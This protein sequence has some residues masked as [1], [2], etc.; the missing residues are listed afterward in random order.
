MGGGGR[1]RDSLLGSW[2]HVFLAAGK[3]KRKGVV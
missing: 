3:K 2:A 1:K